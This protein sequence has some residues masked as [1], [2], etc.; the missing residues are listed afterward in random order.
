M[1][2]D[3]SNL[4][5][6]KRDKSSSKDTLISVIAKKPQKKSIVNQIN[7]PVKDKKLDGNTVKIVT[8]EKNVLS[9]SD[10]END[11]QAVSKLNNKIM[12]KLERDYTVVK[13]NSGIYAGP[14]NKKGERE[15]KGLL[16]YAKTSDDET[17]NQ[18]YGY[19]EKNQING[20]GILTF[21]D[22]KVFRGI[23]KNGKIKYGE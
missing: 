8:P 19:F 2:V 10:I 11:T 12:N 21:N 9:A 20:R 4:K 6:P 1:F 15:G 22:G 16:T 5:I 13:E 7:V 17:R 14:L 23:A 3:V 18:W